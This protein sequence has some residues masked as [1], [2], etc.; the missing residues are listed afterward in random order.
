MRENAAEIQF[1]SLFVL[2]FLMRSY[3][4]QLEPY[5]QYLQPSPQQSTDPTPSPKCFP[6]AVEAIFIAHPA[7]FQRI[8]RANSRCREAAESVEKFVCQRNLIDF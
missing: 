6:F 1:Q 3:I 5:S 8:K 2:H 4:K 7:P